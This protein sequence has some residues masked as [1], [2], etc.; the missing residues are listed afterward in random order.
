MHLADH[1]DWMTPRDSRPR[2]VRFSCRDHLHVGNEDAAVELVTAHMGR[3]RRP[4]LATVDHTTRGR[5]A[6]GKTTSEPSQV[7]CPC[8]RS[9]DVSFGGQLLSWAALSS[10]GIY[11]R[12]RV[13]SVH[14]KPS[15]QRATSGV[16]LSGYHP[17]GM[18][19]GGGGCGG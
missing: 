2:S 4:T 8:G 17:A 1:A 15:H 16:V 12:G 5:S 19:V 14:L 11:W 13:C 10:P 3:S 9:R 6:L 7:R 18:S